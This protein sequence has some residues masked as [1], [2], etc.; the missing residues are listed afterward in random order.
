MSK[1]YPKH[2]L[3]PQVRDN[4]AIIVAR[5]EN[6]MFKEIEQ[7]YGAV[8]LSQTDSRVYKGAIT[9]IFTVMF[10]AVAKE[11]YDFGGRKY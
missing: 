5:H 10:R 3:E 8:H 2:Y 9:K 7:Y 6:A 4:I 1:R 11:Y